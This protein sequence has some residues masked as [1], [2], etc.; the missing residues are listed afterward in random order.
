[1]LDAKRPK[2]SGNVVHGNL[3]VGCQYYGSFESRSLINPMIALLA[4]KNTTDVNEKL[5]KLSPVDWRDFWHY[6]IGRGTETEVS[7]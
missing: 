4:I 7:P 3:F 5:F 2:I 6:A 1:M